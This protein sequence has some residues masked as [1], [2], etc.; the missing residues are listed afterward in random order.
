MISQ[1]DLEQDAER[2]IRFIKLTAWPEIC[3]HCKGKGICPCIACEGPCLVCLHRRTE[4]VVQKIKQMAANRKM[5]F[6]TY[7]HL[8]GKQAVLSGAGNNG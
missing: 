2:L 7:S 1:A 3:W 5:E 8:L 4:V 6:D